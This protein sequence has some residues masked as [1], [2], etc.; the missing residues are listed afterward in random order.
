MTTC[1]ECTSHEPHFDFA[2][3]AYQ[4]NDPLRELIHAFKFNQRTLIRHFFARIMLSHIH[5][6]SF[7]IQQFDML[8][9]I[10]L[11]PT[12]YKERGYNQSELLAYLIGK[13]VGIP[14]CTKYLQKIRHTQNQSAM[15]RKERWTNIQGAFRMKPSLRL[16][17]KKILIIDDLL[18]T[19]ATASE[20]AR[21]LK[22][23]GA[24]LVGVFTLAVA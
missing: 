23:N 5:D 7:D 10:P 12:R 19:G 18:T 9:P 21:I 17:D 15:S 8:V 1:R 6:Y 20:A 3:G 24:K 4:Y 2:W 14:L 11:F 13:E 16:E 22:H